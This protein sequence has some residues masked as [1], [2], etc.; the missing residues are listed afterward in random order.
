MMTVEDGPSGLTVAERFERGL[1]P[2]NLLGG[3]SKG[4]G[5]PLRLIYEPERM[6]RLG[7]EYHSIGR[8]PAFPA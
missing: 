8:R 1:C 7:F 3:G 4:G 6:R 5:A 2:R